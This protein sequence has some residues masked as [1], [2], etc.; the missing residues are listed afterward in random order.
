[1]L[2]FNA[3]RDMENLL[4]DKIREF[5]ARRAQEK[6]QKVTESSEREAILEKFRPEV[7]LEN[8]SHRASQ[9]SIVTHPLKFTHTDAKGTSVLL[10]SQN[11][12]REAFPIS[13]L[14][15][16][17]YKLDVDGNA[18]AL[19]VAN[20]LLLSDDSE[21]LWQALLRG[22]HAPLSPFSSEPRQ[23][24]EWVEGFLGALKST[25]I[26][27]NNLAKQVYFPLGNGDYHLLSPLF[28]SSLGTEIADRID[29]ERFSEE[30]KVARHAKREQTYHSNL[31]VF[32]PKLLIQS[33]GGTKPQNVSLLNSSRRGR[34]YALPSMPPVWTTRGKPKSKRADWFWLRV[35]SYA[36]Y[37]TEKLKEFLEKHQEDDSTIHLRRRRERLERDV[38]GAV[39]SAAAEIQIQKEW[40]GWSKTSSLPTSERLWL[41]PHHEDESIQEIRAKG[42]WEL[43]IA[44]NFARWII[45][46]LE[47]ESLK[48]GDIA[49]THWRDMFEDEL[50][51]S[52]V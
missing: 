22:N 45:Q 5:I 16:A 44:E 52:I 24:N 19:D 28:A 51:E 49:W 40:A 27:S 46:A 15:I 34:F 48:L 3:W 7:W 8:A 9:V 38:I 37:E 18:A 33:F 23:I 41:D 50:K 13:T 1:V 47:S 10:Y 42:G 35:A 17:N 29:R 39:M 36:R 2:G 43:H 20:L 25:E 11:E 6:L 32:Y 21:S 14:S 12:S 26:T 30:A 4:A 31:V